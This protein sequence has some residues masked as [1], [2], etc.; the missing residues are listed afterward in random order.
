MIIQELR[1]K[2][3]RSYGTGPNGSGITIK[4]RPGVN[5]I[6]GYNGHGKSTIIEAIG[7]ALF[8]VKPQCLEN[9]DLNT[10]FVRTGCNSAEIDITFSYNNETYRIERGLGSSNKRRT[11]VILVDNN[12]ICAENEHEV[13]A[14]LCRLLGFVDSNHLSDIFT[15]LIGIK[16]GHLTRPFDSKPSHAKEFFEPLLEVEIFRRCYDQ[17][18]P[19]IDTFDTQINKHHCLLAIEKERI[20]ERQ[21]SPITIVTKR[22]N[23]VTLEQQVQTATNDL[24]LLGDEKERLETTARIIS[25]MTHKRNELELVHS[26]QKQKRIHAQIQMDISLQAISNIKHIEPSYKL[27]LETEFNIKQLRAKQ[28]QQRCLADKKTSSIHHKLELNSSLQSGTDR[29]KLLTDQ[30]E[31][32]KNEL[33]QLKEKQLI[34]IQQLEQ[35]KKDY[36]NRTATVQ[37]IEE[38]IPLIRAFILKLPKKIAHQRQLLTQ[39]IE[40]REKCTKFDYTQL[41]V[42]RDLTSKYDKQL[43][44]FRN[45]LATLLE[46]Q[47]NLRLQQKSLNDG[48]CPFSKKYCHYHADINIEL[49][50]TRLSTKIKKYSTFVKAKSKIIDELKKQRDTLTYNLGTIDNQSNYIEMLTTE[51]QESVEDI[52]SDNI[53][54]HITVLC[55]LISTIPNFPDSSFRNI[56]DPHSIYQAAVNFQRLTQNWWKTAEPLAI[57]QLNQE[58]EELSN[59]TEKQCHIHYQTDLLIRLM[60]EIDLLDKNRCTEREK[61]Q[62]LEI[63]YIKADK[64]ITTCVSELTELNYLDDELT[65]QASIL[66]ANRTNYLQYLSIYLVAK[67]AT[68]REI[69]LQSCLTMESSIVETLTDLDNNL[70]NIQTGFDDKTLCVITKMYFEKSNE[71]A[72]LSANRNSAQESLNLEEQRYAEWKQAYIAKN[73]ILEQIDRFIATKKLGEIARNTLKQT[74]PIVAQH[75]CNTIAARAQKIFNLTNSEPIELLWYANRYSLRIVPGERRFAMLSGGEQNKLALAMVLAMIEEFSNLQLCIFDEPTYGIDANS[76]GKLAEAILTAQDAARME[77]LIIVS[78]DDIF[79]S[80]IEHYIPLTKTSTYGTEIKSCD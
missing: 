25:D 20:R 78:H 71:V 11:K 17:I 63:Q 69:E 66:D 13:S 30:I 29:I 4:F 40:L 33:A 61:L 75:L 67:Q 21:D 77:Q 3:I 34:N 6:S 64:I 16:Q 70:K 74:A 37:R 44:E 39:I 19:A 56:Q 55:S 72:I 32:K 76:R 22:E 36:Q 49:D 79:E 53:L 62:E 1:L 9:F 18:K 7:Y 24:V 68:S 80:Q 50:L 42:T 2:N 54:Q 23:L 52:I 5:R 48:H 59:R 28:D 43:Q 51:L 27:F 10:Y 35:S 31:T 41:E 26:I 65:V 15:K 60:G 46:R 73:Q 14:F 12:N 58:K 38:N 8:E 57:Q 47:Q 45:Q